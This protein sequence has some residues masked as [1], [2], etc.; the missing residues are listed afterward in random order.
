MDPRDLL[1]RLMAAQN[2]NPNSLSARVN[3]RTKQSQIHRFLNGDAKEP[4]RSTLQPIADFF[5]ITIEAFFDER[6][7]DVVAA[8][9]TAGNAIPPSAD[10]AP[11]GVAHEPILTAYTVPSL[12]TWEALTM[13]AHPPATFRV[14]APDDALAPR[15]PRGTELIMDSGAH[16]VPNQVI[17][18]RDGAGQLHLRRYGQGHGG[19]WRALAPNDA[20]LTLESARDG[21]QLLAVLRWVSGEGY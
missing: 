11:A 5:G 17:L 19:A 13:Q 10:P 4:R 2:L 14:A 9:A 7:A 6:A 15:I 16:P 1:R 8:R 3:N 12:T 18:V 20:Y 21:L